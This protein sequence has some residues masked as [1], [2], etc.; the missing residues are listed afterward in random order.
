MTAYY[1]LIHV[2]DLDNMLAECLDLQ[3]DLDDALAE[4]FNLQKDTRGLINRKPP[5]VKVIENFISTLVQQHPP[6]ADT[7]I[8]Y[9]YKLEQAYAMRWHKT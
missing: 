8:N 1:C 2:E 9:R 4:C 5:I 6:L 3:R 7:L